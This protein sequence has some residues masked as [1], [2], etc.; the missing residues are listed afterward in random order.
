[1]KT[2]VADR[3]GLYVDTIL[4]NYMNYTGITC[5]VAVFFYAVQIYAD[6]AGYSLMAIGV[7]KTLGFE[8]TE[9]PLPH[10]SEITFIFR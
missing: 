1:M 5:M 6:F 7:G 10:G 4:P 9:N 8:L 3:A 2:V